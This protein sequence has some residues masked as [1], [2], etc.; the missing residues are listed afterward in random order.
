LPGPGHYG[1]GNV[2]Q[3]EIVVSRH[4]EKEKTHEKF[5]SKIGTKKF[6]T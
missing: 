3:Q 2:S 4:L 6:W 5:N 1:I